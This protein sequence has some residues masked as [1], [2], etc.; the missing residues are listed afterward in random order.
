MNE[1]YLKELYLNSTSE[2]VI[3]AGERKYEFLK[4]NEKKK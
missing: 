2:M 3:I 1:D 4:A